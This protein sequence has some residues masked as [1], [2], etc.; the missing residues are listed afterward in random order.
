MKNEDLIDKYFKSSLSPKEQLLFN[1]LLLNN[2]DFKAEFVFQKDLRKI[3]SIKQQEDLK[4]TLQQFEENIQK[5]STFLFISKR[6]FIAAS[7]A[8]LLGLGFWFVKDTYFISSEKL[9]SQHFEPYR[10][11]IQPIER[12]E[13]ENT[14]E[15]KAFV[16]YEKGDYYKSINLFN[17]VVNSSDTYI[18]FYK[19]MGLLEV[20]KTLDAIDILIEI[21]NSKNHKESDKNFDE[22]ANWYLGLAY[23]KIKENEKAIS[24]FSKIVNRSTDTFKK[25]EA[26]KILIKLN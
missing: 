26:A 8:L 5:K 3:I 14:L 4:S 11:I 20:N 19:A 16:A 1:D 15:F 13:N 18:L 25:E 21:A 12:G 9:Y 24:Q 17:S 2:N 7:L 22:I 6:W 23:L 10:N